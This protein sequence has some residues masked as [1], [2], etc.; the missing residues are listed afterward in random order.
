MGNL[1]YQATDDVVSDFSPLPTGKYLAS[2]VEAELKQTKAGT[3]SYVQ[4]KFE[5]M[6]GAYKGR[7]VSFINITFTNPNSTAQEIGRKQLNTLLKAINLQGIQDTSELTGH[8][9][10]IDVNIKQQEGYSPQNEVKNYFPVDGT[11]AAP[12]VPSQAA[13]EPT[14]QPT[15]TSDA[16]PSWAQ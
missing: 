5:V 6:D 11:P 9:V 7:W 8:A 4:L 15:P 1:D 13:P 3:G 10:V 2:I 12:T 16:Q 14:A